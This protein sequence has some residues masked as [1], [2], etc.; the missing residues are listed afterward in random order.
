MAVCMYTYI[1]IILL[2]WGIK[3]RTMAYFGAPGDVQRDTTTFRV[4]LGAGQRAVTGVSDLHRHD[5]AACGIYLALERHSGWPK[6]HDHMARRQA[7][8]AVG[9]TGMIT[10]APVSRG[11]EEREND[12]QPWRAVY[13]AQYDKEARS[14]ADF[15]N[16]SPKPQAR[17]T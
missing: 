3:Y 10:L 5:K 1:N 2:L 13:N 14:V 9:V 6:Q 16:Q 7:A 4:P 11:E 12:S 17:N 15:R 8:G